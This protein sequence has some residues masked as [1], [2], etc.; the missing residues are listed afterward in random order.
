[1]KKLF[2]RRRPAVWKLVLYLG[3]LGLLLLF[4]WKLQGRPCFTDAA[5]FRQALCD[6]ACPGASL[7]TV[8][9]P[10]SWDHVHPDHELAL[11]S[12]GERCFLVDL[13]GYN[14]NSLFNLIRRWYAGIACVGVSPKE[15]Y[16]FIPYAVEYDHYYDFWRN[17]PASC[18]QEELRATLTMLRESGAGAILVVRAPGADAELSLVLGERSYPLQGR[19]LEGDWFYFTFPSCYVPRLGQDGSLEWAVEDHDAQRK[20]A[21]EPELSEV[22]E[23]CSWLSD[24]I[25]RRFGMYKILLAEACIPP[26]TLVLTVY[27]E[28]GS[29]IDTV[30]WESAA[31]QGSDQT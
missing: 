2:S 30:S 3:L 27:N 11:G 9:A 28:S 31:P 12:D 22:W 20:P 16:A 5:A 23:Y 21:W 10:D 1:M 14:G 15:G 29:V 8:I 7:E 24:Y 6:A 17:D 13:G 18:S 4:F 25:I 26:A 19:K